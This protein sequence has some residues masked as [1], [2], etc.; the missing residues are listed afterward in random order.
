[1]VDA[2]LGRGAAGEE[3]L[4]AIELDLGI[5]ELRSQRLDLGRCGFAL[6][7]DFVVDDHGDDRAGIDLAAFFD[8]DFAD[9]AA[10]TGACGDNVPALDAAEDGL[11]FRDSLGLDDDLFGVG[12]D[13]RHD[14][15]D[16]KRD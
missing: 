6:E 12:C 15:C 7:G 2:R 5:F 8:P 10:D 3:L 13:G 16:G 9:S 1:L 4:G 14:Q 11:E